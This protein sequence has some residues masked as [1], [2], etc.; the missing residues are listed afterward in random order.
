MGKGVWGID[1]SRYSVKAVRL[2]P[3]K[4]GFVLTDVEVISFPITGKIE[5]ADLEVRIRDSLRQL[6]KTK[7]IGNE[8]C[9]LSLP[10]HSH[11]NRL[12]KLPPFGDLASAVQH[13]ARQQI[14]IPL[15][16]ALWGYQIVERNYQP[17][18][19]KDIIL[20]AI[21]RDTVTGFL[22]IVEE[23][24][25]N[26]EAIQLSPVAVYNFL[27]F[28]QDVSL[29]TVVLELGADNGSLI[30]IENERFWVRNLPMA[31]NEVTK[32]IQDGMNLPFT[33]CS[34]DSPS[35]VPAATSATFPPANAS[36]SCRTWTSDLSTS[37]TPY[38]IACR[39]FRS[40]TCGMPKAATIALPSTRQGTFVSVAAFPATGPAT[41]KHAD[42]TS[43]SLAWATMNAETIAVKLA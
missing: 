17:G 40:A 15:E 4:E 23:V 41:P 1:V 10:T 43:S 20:L 22:K 19:E 14:P 38:A 26:I 21:K 7:R 16:E 2:E 9:V 6:K 28:D 34:S 36:P 12:V 27:T 13:E 31:G 30:V 18:E 11:Y 5:E 42:P 35:P 29:P 25:L 39:S 33:L 3:T 24:G 32:A 8:K 37:G